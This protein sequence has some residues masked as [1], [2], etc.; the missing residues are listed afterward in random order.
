MTQEGQV[1]T[2]LQDLPGPLLPPSTSG[3][4]GDC[5]EEKSYP[6]QG[7]LSQPRLEATPALT[8]MPGDRKPL[9]PGEISEPY[10]VTLWSHTGCR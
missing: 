3:L 8:A 10:S 5:W 7:P 4:S 2:F 1:C 6:P 9:R